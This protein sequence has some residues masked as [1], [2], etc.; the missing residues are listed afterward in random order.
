M[1]EIR[2]NSGYDDHQASTFSFSF[3][4]RWHRSARIGPYSSQH[5][6]KG[7]P[8]H[9][10]SVCLVEH[11]SFP[12]SESGVSAA[13]FLNSSFLQPISAV[14]LWSVHV[15]KVPQA[16]EQLCP[17]KLQTRCYICCACQS[18]CKQQKKKKKKKKKK[19]KQTPKTKT[20]K[21]ANSSTS[22]LLW[23]R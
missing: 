4:S 13:S 14:K 7:C 8:R 3:S 12:T 22:N 17:A 5:S 10:A 21:Q 6:P 11:D 19:T 18:T 15:Q 9:S 20:N 23:M 16:S 2:H 1:L